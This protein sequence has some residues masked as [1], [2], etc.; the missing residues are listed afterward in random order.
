[1]ALAHAGCEI[2]A[3]CPAP[4]PMAK[5]GVVRC[6]YLYRGLAPLTSF[7]RA[8]YDAAP[9]FIVSGDDLAT[10]HLHALHAREKQ[11]ETAGSACALIERSLGNPQGF[12]ILRARAAFLDVCRDEGIR[13]P[14][15]RALKDTNDL[16]DWVTRTGLPTVVK[17]DG[18]S[19]G[20]GV[21]VVHTL[22]GAKAAFRQLQAPPLLARA[23]KRALIDH[24]RTLVWPSIRRQRPVVNVQAFVAGRE[25]NSTVFCDQ[26]AVLAGLHFV[27]VNKASSAGH[28][29][30]V[31]RIENTEMSAAVERVARRLGLSGFYGFDFMLEGET[32]NAYLV[33]VNPRATQV[34]H[35]SLGNGRDLPAALYAVLTGTVVK[36]APE[37]TENETIALFPQEWSRDPH[38]PFLHSAYHDVPWE[39][40]ELVRACIGQ[41]DRQSAWY[42]R[43]KEEQLLS[44]PRTSG[45]SAV[46][47]KSRAVG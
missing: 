12:P 22:A 47:L 44:G 30:V 10:Q 19:G 31:R 43:R 34:G 9:D 38:S 36:P 18:T 33:E 13:V 29:T 27:V 39:M 14:A 7:A 41:R 8:I 5:I 45:A 23:A 28:S 16:A 17:A 4:H 40:P 24:D 32:G 1:M 35:L 21:R 26:G 11:N 37:I 3:V 42:W 25:A 20:D 46:S 2:D 6:I 15:T